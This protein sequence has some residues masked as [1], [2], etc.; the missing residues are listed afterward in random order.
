MSGT[1]IFVAVLGLLVIIH[2]FGHFIVAKLCGVKVE[3]FSIGFGPQILSKKIGE[4]DFVISILPFGGFVKMA[5]ENPG[6]SEGHAWE[7]NSKSALQKFWIVSAGPLMNALLA[8][9]IFSGI[10]M[11]GQPTLTNVVGKIMAESPA[12]RS[13]IQEGDKVIS[14]NGA[15]VKFWTDILEKIHDS[16]GNLELA[17]ERKGE[18]VTLTVVPDRKEIKDIFGKTRSISFVGIAPSEHDDAR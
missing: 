14:L 10:F 1:L 5:G 7:F 9:V 18:P 6:E 4:T 12:Q 15:P 17:I 2:E 8:F 16:S 11:V 13:G 3:M